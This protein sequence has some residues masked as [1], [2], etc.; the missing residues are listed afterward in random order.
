MNEID[1]SRCS[2]DKSI[3]KGL[4]VILNSSKKQT[5]KIDLSTTLKPQVNLFLFIFWK[6]LKTSKDISK[7][8]YTF[9]FKSYRPTIFRESLVPMVMPKFLNRAFSKP[10]I[11]VFKAVKARRENKR[12]KKYLQILSY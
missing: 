2:K 12:M 7:L 11:T 9:R 10:G 8:T 6:N 3:Q 1:K 4:F 5:K